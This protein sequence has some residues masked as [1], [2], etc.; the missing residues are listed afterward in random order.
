M[1][2][3]P[4]AGTLICKSSYSHFSFQAKGN[5][6]LF[7]GSYE[8]SIDDKGR[9]AI[10]ARYRSLVCGE[11]QDGA[12][13]LTIFGECLTAYPLDE[14]HKLGN[15]ISALP[16]FNSQVIA[17]QR[18]FISR[19]CECAIDKSGRILIP[20]GLRASAKLEK[21]CTII[22]QVHKFEIWSSPTWQKEFARISQDI[23][24]IPEKMSTFGI[25]L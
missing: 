6:A 7:L 3:N 18:L 13:I 16:Q 5:N 9:L 4:V 21:D 2:L 24:A 20:P 19:A 1:H 12:V 17:F 25:H 14:W 8:H 23:G 22:G 11:N 10:P 15:K